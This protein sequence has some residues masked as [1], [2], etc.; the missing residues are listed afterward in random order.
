MWGSWIAYEVKHLTGCER[1]RAF[2]FVPDSVGEDPRDDLP[3]SGNKIAKWLVFLF[4]DDS[5]PAATPSL[6]DM[7]QVGNDEHL[8]F[9]D[10]P[11]AVKH[12]LDYQREDM[13]QHQ[14]H[15]LRAFGGLPD[16][17]PDGFGDMLNVPRR[18][19]K[20]TFPALMSRI[21]ITKHL[22]VPHVAQRKSPVCAQ[23][24]GVV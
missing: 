24:P 11:T 20:R 8:G 2:G 3:R 13:A 21:R 16:D 6:A 18:A 1:P 10:A 12:H 15:F 19:H 7:D 23:A 17:I 14:E 5:C 22:P 9:T 4:E